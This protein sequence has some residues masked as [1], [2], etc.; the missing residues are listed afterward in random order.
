MQVISSPTIPS[1]SRNADVVF[2]K[3][4]ARSFGSPWRNEIHSVLVQTICKEMLLFVIASVSCTML[5]CEAGS[6]N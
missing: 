6:A 4:R 5:M 1:E 3:I 2:A